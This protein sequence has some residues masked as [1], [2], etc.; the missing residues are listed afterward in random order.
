MTVEE[1][2]EY[3][4]RYREANK[5]KLKEHGKVY[6]EKRKS[7]LKEKSLAYYVANKETIKKRTNGYYHTNKTKILVRDK[8][9]RDNNK[10]KI[11]ERNKQYRNKNKIA[12]AA[13]DKAYFQKNKNKVILYK[14]N[15]DKLNK[16]KI[17]ANKRIYT[18]NRMK[19]DL[20]FRL[21]R[22][23]SNSVRSAF[24]NHLLK[25]KCKSSS[26]LGCSVSEFKN[27]IEAKF[28]PWMNWDNQGKCNGELNYGWDLDHKIPLSSAKTEE[29]L[30]AL[31]HYTN[32]QPLCSY[33]NRSVKKDKL[34][35]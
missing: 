22:N 28:E 5:E 2:K 15:Y 25:K 18:K 26:L 19:N 35:Y 13:R 1:E 24:K 7:E 27:Y 31:F 33:I 21:R 14:K 34:I 3:Q 11:K 9:Y 17:N 6:R 20:L 8:E 16:D 23:Y 12:K 29:E 4:K 32:Y 10:E 30:K